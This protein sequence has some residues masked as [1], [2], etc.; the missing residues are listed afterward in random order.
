VGVVG[1]GWTFFSLALGR[2]WAR[3]EYSNAFNGPYSIENISTYSHPCELFVLFFVIFSLISRFTSPV[4]NIA[5]SKERLFM[6]AA[7]LCA[8][9]TNV[10]CAPRLIYTEQPACCNSPRI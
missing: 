9:R 3:R 5:G 1:N 10:R 7:S 6:L 2:D 8:E 4:K